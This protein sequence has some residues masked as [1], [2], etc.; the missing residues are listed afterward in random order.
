MDLEAEMA[1]YWGEENL[2]LG[3]EKRLACRRACCH[4]FQSFG[5]FHDAISCSLRA[6]S[7]AHEKPLDIG[8]GIPRPRFVSQK[9]GKTD[10][11]VV[12]FSQQIGREPNP[13]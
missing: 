5:F 7:T 1:T 12:F 10:S 13:A 2:G 4:R 9:E 8:H 11:L 6:N 3:I